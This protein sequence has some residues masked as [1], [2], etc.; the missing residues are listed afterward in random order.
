MKSIKSLGMSLVFAASFAFSSC[1][2]TDTIDYDISEQTG[3]KVI[4][5][6]SPAET[7]TRATA[8]HDG[9]KLRYTAI[10]MRGSKSNTNTTVYIRKELIDGETGDEGKQNHLV[11]DVDPD[12][13][14]TLEVFADYIPQNATLQNA[15]FSDK[16]YQT[17]GDYYYDTSSTR[18]VVKMM[19]TPQNKSTHKVAP[20]FFNN[21]NYDCFAMVQEFKKTEKNV[22]I[23]SK[24]KRIVA[25]VR[26][27]DKSSNNG[28]YNVGVSQLGFNNQYVFVNDMSSNAYETSESTFSE[29]QVATS[30]QINSAN[31][32]EV[33]S[34]YTFTTYPEANLDEKVFLTFST[35]PSSGEKKSFS[36][37][38]IIIKRNNITTVTGEF[39]SEDK[40]SQGGTDNPNE[41]FPSLDAEGPVHL[42]LGIETD[43]WNSSSSSWN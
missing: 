17:Y 31:D 30:K 7:E 34:F 8:N 26:Y 18:D 25:K 9:H 6:L 16:T 36:T 21:D 4:L 27:I 41:D 20:E 43:E 22:V 28:T 19:P 2:V 29:I 14:Y 13:T 10:L 38:D 1:M 24:L 42:Y 35:S 39:L 5:N 33:V 37:K 32:K 40:G 11:F 15:S 3:S 23:N 12:V